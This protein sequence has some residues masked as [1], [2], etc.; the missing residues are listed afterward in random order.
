VLVRPTTRREATE[1]LYD[2]TLCDI[3]PCLRM[4]E[5][6]SA[7]G[8]ILGVVGFTAWTA[9]SAQL[10]IAIDE[11]I[12][13]RALT[14]RAC[15]YFFNELGMAVVVGLTPANNPAALRLRKGIGFRTT[16]AIR[17]GWARGVDL[18]IG[19]MRAADCRCL[20]RPTRK[21]AA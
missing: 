15:D 1:W 9:S 6:V 16:G 4:V 10:H 2:R 5:A 17:D 13:I 7:S 21:K 14:R 8:H 20:Q 11:P 12:C 19:E 3:G 18:L